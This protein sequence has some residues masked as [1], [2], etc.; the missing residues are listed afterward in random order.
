MKE[1]VAS[2]G[3]L[4]RVD[5][6]T[7]DLS[8]PIMLGCASRLLFIIPFRQRFSFFFGKDNSLYQKVF[9]ESNVSYCSP[10]YLQGHDA[11]ECRKAYGKASSK[12]TGSKAPLS[13][14]PFSTS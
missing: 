7:L 5:D 2:F 10:C 14:K 6:R 11:S 8:N 3:T 12:V 9:Y 13:R 1:I 4:L